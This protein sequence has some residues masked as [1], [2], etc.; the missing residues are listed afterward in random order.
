MIVG[1]DFAT[2]FLT[3]LESLKVNVLYFILRR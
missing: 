3:L 1:K 2:V